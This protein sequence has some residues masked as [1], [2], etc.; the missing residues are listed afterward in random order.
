VV[1]LLLTAHRDLEAAKRFSR[2]MLSAEP[3]LAPDR[4]GTD[5]AG[6]YLPAIAESRK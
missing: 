4:I 1:N 6:P 2:K 3:L 5:G